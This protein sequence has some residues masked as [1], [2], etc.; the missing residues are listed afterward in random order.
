[1]TF[2]LL[3]VGGVAGAWSRY[4]GTRLI[5][6]HVA[7]RFPLATLLINVSGSLALGLIYGLI[8]SQP[9]LRGQHMLLLF[10]TGFCGAYTTFSSFAFETLQ[11]WRTHHHAEA[12]ANIIVQPVLG[13]LGAWL[14]LWLGTRF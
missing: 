8:G 12:I 1:V 11:L 4:Y 2:F 3:V 14:G 9:T 7:H 10:G 13:L 5:Q 6:G